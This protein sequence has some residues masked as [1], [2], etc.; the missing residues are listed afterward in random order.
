M[1]TTVAI[2]VSLSQLTI[3]NITPINVSAGIAPTCSDCCARLGM[4]VR[5]VSLNV[6]QELSP[7]IR[8]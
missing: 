4:L 7:L 8:P 2:V 5:L 6:P 3:F 1:I